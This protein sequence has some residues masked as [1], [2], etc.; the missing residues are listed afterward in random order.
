[1]SSHE[2]M[3]ASIDCMFRAIELVHERLERAVTALES[4][5][6]PYALVGAHAVAAWVATGDSEG[7]RN[8]PNVDLLIRRA[9]Q[10]TAITVLAKAGFVLCS[11]LKGLL[12]LDGSNGRERSGLRVFFANERVRTTDQFAMP[13]L[14]AAQQVGRYRV[15]GL[16]ELVTMKLALRR[17]I[18]RV[19]IRDLINVGLI[20]HSWLSRFPPDLATRLKEIL[21]T[22]NG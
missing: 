10:L 13:D 5:G 16:S 21:D 22:P 2:I 19:H 1:M 12:F 4:V 8:T 15:I 7:I 17:T 9:D 6:I 14:V 18:D 11:E 20:D 3:P